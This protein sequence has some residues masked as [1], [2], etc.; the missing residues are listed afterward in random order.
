M[1]V[2]LVAAFVNICKGFP[3]K[4]PENWCWKVE[5]ITCTHAIA[6]I[7]WWLTQLLTIGCL[8]AALASRRRYWMGRC[9]G[10][11]SEGWWWAFLGLQLFL[12]S[13]DTFLWCKSWST[14]LTS[15]LSQCL[16]CQPFH[17]WVLTQC[18]PCAWRSLLVC[19][20]ACF[21][22]FLLSD[23]CIVCHWFLSLCFLCSL[24][25]FGWLL[26]CLSFRPV[27][28]SKQRSIWFWVGVLFR[29]RSGS[30][31]DK[32]DGLVWICMNY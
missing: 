16:I 15:K 22:A 5:P 13:F 20:L 2:S 11:G 19:S 17:S 24:C 29:T 10:A 3:V 4:V 31:G 6:G 23:Y 28:T 12:I 7:G 1:V 21:F 26:A 27:R 14:T 8:L 25:L 30:R 9:F 32:G 18:T